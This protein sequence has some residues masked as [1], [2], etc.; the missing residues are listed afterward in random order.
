[1]TNCHICASPT[2][3]FASA[4]ILGKYQISYFVCSSCRFI[5]TE[6]PYWLPEAYAE[7]I[8]RSDVGHVAR[9]LGFGKI[10]KAVIT[11]FLDSNARF[12]D[13]GGGWGLLVRHMRDLGFDF[14][15]ADK[16]CANLFAPDYEARAGEGGPFEML[17]T[18]EV[19]EHL[20][21]PL[22]GIQAM[23][24]FSQN[25]L[26]STLL[27]PSVRPEPGEWWYYGLDHGQHVSFYTL[28]SLK[29]IARKFN[30]HLCSD[31]L[32]WHLLSKKPVSP[33]LFKLA[34]RNKAAGLLHLMVRRRSLQL[35]D[36][37]R[38]M[39]PPGPVGKK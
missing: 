10:T 39:Q 38:A 37:A 19:F 20:P 3:K 17:T 24:G 13:Y 12:V 25:I 14:W 27:Q 32:G 9:N 22:E 7:P 35:A 15:R 34:T 30:L 4:T 31:G 2:E 28:D 23:L 18:F 6:D 11:L 33:L 5:Q 1:M 36:H 8:K 29:V 21:Q 26:F 16:Y